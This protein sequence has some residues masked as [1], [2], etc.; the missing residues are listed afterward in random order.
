MNYDIQ[1]I[2]TDASGNILRVLD[3]PDNGAGQQDGGGIA[4]P[5]GHKIYLK[6]H[7]HGAYDY[8]PNRYYTLNLNYFNN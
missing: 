4:V 1:F 2:E 5:S 6:I 3:M 7:S 8:D